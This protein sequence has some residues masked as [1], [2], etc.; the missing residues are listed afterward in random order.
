MMPPAK[1]M[2]TT[3]L[4]VCA[5][6]LCSEAAAQDQLVIGVPLEPPNLDPTSGAAAAVDSVVYGNVFEGLVRI[7]QSGDV[8]PALAE[9]WD[10]SADGLIYT[11]R[12]R[13]NVRFHDGSAFDADDVKFSLDRLLAPDSTNAQ[14][15]LFSPIRAVEVVDPHTVS[16]SLDRPSSSL[17]YFLGW[18]D[19]VVVAPESA[20]GNANRPVG[21]GPFQFSNW[22]RGVSIRLDRNRDYWGVPARSGS[23]LFR[24][25]GDPAA[26][27]AAMRAGDLDAYPNYPAPENV[28]EFER[29]PN[30]KV[31]I[32]STAGK[33][34]MAMNNG[35]PPFDNRLVRE[36]VSHAVDRDAVIDGALFGFGEPI[37]SHYSR[38]GRAWVDLA[39]RY[40]H[41][42]E[43]ARALL[44]QAGYADGFDVTLRLPPR[45]YARRSGE[46]IA[47]QLAR[48]GIR[49]QIENLEWAQW[50][51]QVFG[52]RE[53]DLTII[54]HIEPMDFGIY[55]RADYYFGYDDP[56][57]RA[58]V[59]DYEAATDDVTRDELLR[60]I[61]VKL[62]DDAVNVFLVQSA[63]LG[64]WKA[65]LTGLWADTPI[66]ANIAAYAALD[67]NDSSAGDGPAGPG[68]AWR[69]LAPTA[70][71]L[72]VVLVAFAMRMMGAAWLT[73]RLVAHAGTLLAATAVIFVILQIVPGDPAAYMMGM[74]A[75]PESIASLRAQMGLDGPPLERYLGWLGGLVTGQLGTSYTY[76]V[77]VGDLI[78]ERLAVSLPLAVLAILISLVVALPA[79]VLAAS[80]RGRFVDTALNA[81]MQLGVAMPNFWIG[82]L[83]ILLFSTQLRWFAA[84]G[85]VGWD[86]GVLPALKDLLLPAIALAAPQAAITA[87]VLR[88][89]LLET[90]S[91]D[92][93]RT[94]RAKGLDARQALWRHALRNAMIPVLTIIGLQLPFLLAGGIIIENVFS[95]P[96]IGRLVF[97]AI[98][99]RD[100][101]V[102]QN[103]VFVL[104][105]A[106]VTVTFL[107][108][109]AYSVVDPRLRHSAR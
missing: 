12:L 43:R 84:G 38:Q 29:D 72:V 99:Q 60:R 65:G 93:I 92:Y 6:A 71:L 64:I 36:A 34:I 22:R 21:T 68:R 78:V 44:A 53:F 52:R 45:P 81:V 25:I 67:G 33:V 54:E 1:S 55:A 2:L 16:L 61:Q 86:A 32:G 30:F 26:A 82:L 13:R 18:G 19:A 7:T 88:T 46:V 42:P 103:V 80:Q 37:G 102:V 50:L 48:V 59:A 47:A 77:P 56:A 9:S 70:V 5:M 79:G 63:Q 101:I 94:A 57:Y 74:N 98:T 3:L 85:F 73:G 89:A 20:A 11:F 90:M 109:V 23:V 91:E 69:L 108:D 14:K 100:L 83:L 66:P 40:P 104:V 4:A 62:A 105:L 106:V 24:I 76:L 97:Q 15:A 31:V 95:L 41:D 8:A 51:D 75:S 96:G 87:R 49:V 10:I 58:L 35:R 107:I 28:A 39:G 17:L 27:Y